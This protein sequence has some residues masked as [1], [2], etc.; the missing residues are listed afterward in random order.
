MLVQEVR[1]DSS[2]RILIPA[3]MRKLA[4]IK[5]GERVMVRIEGRM[6]VIRAL[7]EE[8]KLVSDYVEAAKDEGRAA[9]IKE[10]S[11][12]DAEDWE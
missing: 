5:C 9:E 10:W 6:I 11:A 1:V 12:L 3:K 4:G 8:D 2:G 7:N